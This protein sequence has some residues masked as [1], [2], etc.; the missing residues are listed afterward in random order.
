MIVG[1]GWAISDSADA[2]LPFLSP[3]VVDFF[4]FFGSGSR[5]AL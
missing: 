5:G 2:D 3:F 4:D 1:G